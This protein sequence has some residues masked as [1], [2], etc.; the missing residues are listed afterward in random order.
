MFREYDVIQSGQCYDQAAKSGVLTG[1]VLSRVKI[2]AEIKSFIHFILYKVVDV[3]EN[4]VFIHSVV[5]ENIMCFY[6]IVVV[7]RMV[8]VAEHRC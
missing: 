5:F 1:T 3:L 2:V 7:S 8:N 6:Y 4:L